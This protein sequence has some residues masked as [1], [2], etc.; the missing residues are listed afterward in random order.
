MSLVRVNMKRLVALWL[1]ML[2]GWSCGG[3]AGR[4]NPCPNGVVEGVFW[5]E[6]PEDAEDLAGCEVITSALVVDPHDDLTTVDLPMLLEIGGYLLKL[7]GLS[8]EPFTMQLSG[9]RSLG[10]GLLM[11][12]SPSTVV[13]DLPELVSVGGDLEIRTNDA[14][15]AVELPKLT[16][17]ADDLLFSQNEDEVTFHA[18]VLGA[19]GGDLWAWTA[20]ELPILVTIGG[21]RRGLSVVRGEKAF[22]GPSGLARRMGQRVLG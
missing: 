5:I 9:L 19:V 21:P 11:Q 3:D 17:I 22:D 20:L 12:N 18:P 7:G 16:S 4:E 1:T 2:N 8:G 13:L 10:G 6:T 15:V 14:P